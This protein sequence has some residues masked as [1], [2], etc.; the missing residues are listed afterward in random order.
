MLVAA[1][2]I[3]PA[4]FATLWT[5]TV[6]DLSASLALARGESIPWVGPSINF[7]PNLGPISLWLVAPVLA[8]A[9]SLAA[10]ATWTAALASLKFFFLFHLGRVLSGDRLGLCFVAGAAVPSIAAFQWTMFLHPNWVEAAVSAALLLAALSVRRGS[11][12]LAHACALVLGLAVQLHPSALFYVPLLA[13]ILWL[14]ARGTRLLLHALVAAALVC[15]WFLPTLLADEGA[16]QS[17]PAG[18]ESVEGLCLDRHGNRGECLALSLGRVASALSGFSLADAST[19]VKTAY[20]AVPLAVGSY[21]E[22]L[23]IPLWTWALALAA[24][25]AAVLAG[26]IVRL[27]RAG[28]ERRALAISLAA[29]GAG[30]I[31]AAAVKQPTPFYLCYFLLPLSAI[32]AGAAFDA[33]ASSGNRALRSAGH[34]SVALAI[35]AFVCAAVGARLVGARSVIES[36]LPILGD[37]KHPLPGPVRATLMTAAS[38]DALANEICAWR[39]VTLHGEPAY[40]LAASTGLDLRLHCPARQPEVLILGES[41]SHPGLTAIPVGDSAVIG[42]QPTSRFKGLGGYRVKAALHPAKGRPIERRWVSFDRLWD[43]QPMTRVTLAFATAP[44]DAFMVYR[45]KPFDSRWEGFSVKRGGVAA[46]ASLSTY[47][48]WVYSSGS[49]AAEWRVE[50]ETDAP[51][52]VDVHVF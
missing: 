39:G 6:R 50:F 33:L 9:P 24:I 17:I 15:S 47:N 30:W 35:A 32:V 43:R 40:A 7:G 46:G 44:G 13:W 8:V 5:D 41:G 2:S 42:R 26:I 16:A 20:V 1:A 51:Q 36:R 49:S 48:S 29:L 22:Q 11:M 4:P 10:A 3:L 19:V 38:R 25:A 37:L 27:R 12:P 23:G 28:A 52:W 34:A 31:V 45:L 14:R 21:A 18:A